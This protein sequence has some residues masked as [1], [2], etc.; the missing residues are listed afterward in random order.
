MNELYYAVIGVRVVVAI[1][2]K[3]SFLFRRILNR[4]KRNVGLLLR[5]DK[6]YKRFFSRKFLVVTHTSYA[7]MKKLA[8]A[9]KVGRILRNNRYIDRLLIVLKP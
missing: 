5:A 2:L 4:N 8:F 3:N 9:Y 1:T 6:E 7:V